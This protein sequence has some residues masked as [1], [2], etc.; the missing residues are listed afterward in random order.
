MTRPKSD[1]LTPNLAT[2]Y[3]DGSTTTELGIKYGLHHAAISRRLEK[4]GV[5]RRKAQ[6]R[7][8][9]D[10]EEARQDMAYAYAHGEPVNAIA[11]RLSIGRS[12]VLRAL[13]AASMPLR[14]KNLRA[15]TITMPSDP[16][17]LG[18]I[19]GMFD[20]EG[21][22][23]F[24]TKHSGR[25]VTCKVSIYSTTPEVIS[26]FVAQMGGKTLWDYKRQE[27]KGWKPMG[28]WT[29]YRAQDVAAF[30]EAVLPFLII[31]RNVAEKALALFRREFF[32]SPP[33]SEHQN[34]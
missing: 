11:K 21:N 18:Y 10:R 32:N 15:Q 13:H 8:V 7:T 25:S 12:T 31:K 30:L 22:L 28:V 14:P 26:W 20:G 1:I 19:A 16:S 23:Q 9:Y 2:E 24:R 6:R 17:V 27:R 34:S 5:K 33:A 4:A 29:V 3:L